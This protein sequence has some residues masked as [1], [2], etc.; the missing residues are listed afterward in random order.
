MARNDPPTPASNRQRIVTLEV[1]IARLDKV[2]DRNQHDLDIQLQRLGQLQTDLDAI[3]AAWT[4]LK[5]SRAR[6]S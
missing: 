6:G 5:V 1:Q 4:N 2:I 3:S